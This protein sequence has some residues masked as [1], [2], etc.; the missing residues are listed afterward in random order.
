MKRGFIVS[1]SSLAALA[2]LAGSAAAALSITP[3]DVIA[4]GGL[5][6]GRAVPTPSGFTWAWN[7]STTGNPQIDANGRVYFIGM[8]T[9]TPAIGSISATQG[10]RGVFTGTNASD[11][12]LYNGL[13]D[14]APLG[15]GVSVGQQTSTGV[16][17]I[18]GVGGNIWTSGNRI[19]IGI[20]NQG[21]GI[22]NSG[23][24]QNNSF[25]QTGTFGGS[26]QTIAQRNG[27]ITLASAAGGTASGNITT[28]LKGLSLQ[29]AAMNSAGTVVWNGTVAAVANTFIAGTPT[30]TPYGNNLFTAVTD[31]SGVTTVIAQGGQTA[32]GSV[33]GVYRNAGNGA[34]GFNTKINRNGQV[35]FDGQMLNV[36]TVTSTND[37][38]GV[39]WTPGVGS[40]RVYREGQAAPDTT[41][42][43]NADGQLYSGGMNVARRGFSNA[44][45]LF[46]ASLTGGTNLT[47]SGINQNDSGMW[48]ANT[49]GTTRVFQRNDVAPGF[50][51]AQNVRIGAV[52]NAS[53][54]MN[55][56]GFINAGITLQGESITTGANVL[57]D[58]S[59]PP[60]VVTPGI[61][62]NDL[63]IIAG[64]AGNLRMLARR[65]DPA[66]GTPGWSF[67][68]EIGSQAVWANNNNQVI[69]DCSVSPYHVGDAIGVVGQTSAASILGSFRVLYGW[70]DTFGT[71]PLMYVGQT[72][73]VDPG[74]FKTVL[75]WTI[76]GESNGDGAGGAFN[77]NGQF[78]AS[79]KFTDNSWA[80]V[81]LTV[82]APSAGGL[83]LLGFGALA[84]RRRR[85]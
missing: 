72:L 60:K 12:S 57:F 36:G 85:A 70:S 63:A 2:G 53:V 51:A 33:T 68:P 52:N 71:V 79:V 15:G 65:G 28:D 45:V 41:G 5:N 26:T 43:P 83:A 19:A 20:G 40:Q 47:T 73:E 66:P 81:K 82:P 74:V 3:T 4:W 6:Q 80:V 59:T 14:S 69:F 17:S 7:N 13:Y 10:P 18:T 37:N 50:T 38:I 29:N 78:A 55:N 84:R 62:G 27:T 1:A 58:F 9:S 8:F 75:Q 49:S 24:G 61:F 11:L 67:D 44:G 39:I 21:T 35:Y 16:F 30:T 48:I 22:V 56:S 25:L 42:S 23:T 32:A 31:S 77:D 54:G 64:T 76:F 34:G 46:T